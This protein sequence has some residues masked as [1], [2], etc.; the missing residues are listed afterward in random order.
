MGSTFSG[1]SIGLSGLAAAQLGQDVTGHNIANAGTPGYSVQQADLQAMDPYTTAD[2]STQLHGGMLGTGVS[3][4]A[5]TRSRDQFLDQQVRYGLSDV[6]T[7]T[8]QKEALQKMESAFGEPSDHGLNA[9]L[10]KLFQNFNELVNN[11]EDQGVRASVIQGGDA[12]ARV[13]QG[14]QDRLQGVGASLVSKQNAALDTLNSYGRQIAA[15]NITIQ[16]S[17]AGKQTANDLLDRRDLLL[18]K[19]ASLANISIVNNSDGT[20]N[21]AVGTSDL[22]TG[23]DSHQLALTGPNSLMGRGD[24]TGGEMGGVVKAQA[25]LVG[26]QSDLDN[27]AQSLITTVNAVHQNGAGLDGSTGL[28]FFTGTDAATIAVNPALVASPAKLA[29]AA[30][31]ASG[32]PPPGDASNA[33][34][35]GALQNAPVATIGG[36]TLQGFFQTRVSNLAGQTSASTTQADSSTANLNQLSNQRDGVTGVSTDTELA[37]MLKYQRAY[38]ASAR[39]V[40]TMD[41]MIGTLITGLFGN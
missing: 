12:L 7:Q 31:P 1:I 35:L 6:G 37:N 29:A 2:M 41:E 10:G 23:V 36:A 21:V 15:I 33:T 25:D 8:S 40:K 20:I 16:Q 30:V 32:L 4:R 34:L 11:P 9:N 19:V 39:V 28:A 13:F 18:D 24:L 26:Y 38:E 14:V 22:V 27:L 17:G 3:V 5:I